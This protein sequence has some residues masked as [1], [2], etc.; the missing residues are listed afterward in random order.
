MV[1]DYGMIRV[2]R[3]SKGA[4]KVLE[5]KKMQRINELAKKKKSHGLSEKESAEQKSLR[6]EYLKSFR[7]SFRNQLESIEWTD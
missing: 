4:N 6:E 3:I 2:N 1:L 7:K 5:E